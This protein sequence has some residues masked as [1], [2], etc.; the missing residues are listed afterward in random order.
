MAKLL[1]NKEA[2]G[3]LTLDG[4]AIT[5]IEAGTSKEL[6]SDEA[7]AVLPGIIDIH[8]HGGGL[9]DEL[10]GEFRLRG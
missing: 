10:L 2:L 5:S 6:K 7:W 3:S 4:G 8:T 9:S 1:R